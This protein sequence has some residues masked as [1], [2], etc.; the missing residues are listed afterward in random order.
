MLLFGT[1][2][3]GVEAERLGLANISVP[4]E[5]LEQTAEE[6]AARVAQNPRDALV[7]GKAATGNVSL[8]IGETERPDVWEVQGRG[9]LALARVAL[10]AAPEP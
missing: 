2:F 5:E 9:E 7:T 8:R 6:W 4:E 10:D 3:S 1:E